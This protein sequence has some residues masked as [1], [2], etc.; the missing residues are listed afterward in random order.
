[1]LKVNNK[2]TRMTPMAFHFI[3]RDLNTLHFLTSCCVD[4]DYFPEFQFVVTTG[5]IKSFSI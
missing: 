2:D 1:M 3:Y 4:G 5:F